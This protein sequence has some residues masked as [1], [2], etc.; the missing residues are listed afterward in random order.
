M[1]LLTFS[2]VFILTVCLVFAGLILFP[3]ILGQAATQNNEIVFGLFLGP[4]CVLF[5]LGWLGEKLILKLFQKN[6]D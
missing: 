6:P 2:V 5:V 1:K 4:F 3:D